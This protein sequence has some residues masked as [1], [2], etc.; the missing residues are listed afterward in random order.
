[1][2]RRKFGR[3]AS[4]GLIAS[5]LAAPM[6][7]HAVESTIVTANPS[8]VRTAVAPTFAPPR[9]VH[10]FAK[11]AW[12]RGSACDAV[13]WDRQAIAQ[14]FYRPDHRSQPIT[15]AHPLG[16]SYL[17]IPVCGPMPGSR[18]AYHGRTYTVP[19]V[20]WNFAGWGYPE[21]YCT[22]L[23]F[24]F[25]RQVY[26]VS[27]YAAAGG[28][29][30][31][32]YAAADGGGLRRYWN[33]SHQVPQPGDIISFKA[34]PSAASYIRIYLGHVA[35]VVRSS[36]NRITGNGTLL[37]LTQND[38]INGWRTVAVHHFVVDGMGAG[39]AYLYVTGWLHDPRN[40][41]A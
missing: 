6:P 10:V 8:T 38:T 9:A 30:V 2:P 24:R 40:R 22:E 33:G 13:H 36:V 34:G 37:L 1:M 19:E 23:A 17:G 32:N 3:I 27:P 18:V 25:M 21:F 39:Y 12:W 16:A 28:T 11:P 14:G 20:M 15:A 31:E 26:G 4:A 5:A 29:V 35:V 7:A 41:G